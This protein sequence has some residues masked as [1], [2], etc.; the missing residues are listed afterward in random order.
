MSVASTTGS[1]LRY[2]GAAGTGAGFASQG[3]GTGR[4]GRE[5][6]RLGEIIEEGLAGTGFEEIG[7][8]SLSTG[9]YSA[10]PAL[11]EY[12]RS[13]HPKVSVSLPSLKIGSIAEEEI[14]LLAKGARGGFTFALEA[15]TVGLRDRL[16]KDIDTDMLMS[17]LPLL[18][19]LGWR[20]VK[21][22]FMIGFP[23]EAEEDLLAVRDLIRPFVKCGMEVNLSVSPFTPKPHTPFQ[24]L[25]ME[26]EEALREKAQI[27]RRA[28]A[29]R[30][31]KITIRDAKTARVEALISRGDE[32]LAPLFEELHA[33]GVRLEAWTEFF[34]P[35]LY[36]G[37]LAAGD[38]LEASLL[39]ARKTDQGLPWDFISTG[40]DKSF[41]L[42]E[43]DAA[44]AGRKTAGCY[45][46]CAGCGI[47]C[48]SGRAGS[49]PEVRP[50]AP[51][52]VAASVPGAAQEDGP[53][54]GLPA[55]R[56]VTIRYAK[57]G[58]ARYIGHLDTVDILLRA[59]RSAGIRMRM[60]GK[61]HP[62]PRVSLSAALPVGIESTCE[63]IEMEAE[64]AQGVETDAGFAERINA[65][66]PA[67]MRVMEAISGPMNGLADC[68][69]LL[70]GKKGLD[71]QVIGLKDGPEKAFYRSVAGAR[72]KDLWLSGDFLR[73]V[74]AENRRIDG[75]R[76]Y[77]KFDLQ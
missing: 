19:R 21:L 53:A 62:K 3:S 38:G 44:E 17:R 72:I 61:Y 41:L 67:G 18:R 25:T 34:N 39:G 14:E 50:S 46:S 77:N 10:L 52:P 45:S 28:A 32:R 36:E 51:A 4:T 15:S 47:G 11:I 43:M 16:N 54:A 64:G 69:Y 20:K 58:E 2:R 57:R 49:I 75:I 59:I 66:L 70:V 13:N 71:E 68:G 24:W 56:T 1:T 22:Y 12:I 37:W 7:L 29:G 9:D 73:I 63:M 31:V 40:V 27:V 65:R 60:H 55:F 23:W 42:A 26:T 35:S 5:S 6:G 33:K 30:G 8:L 74:K 76:A 48:A